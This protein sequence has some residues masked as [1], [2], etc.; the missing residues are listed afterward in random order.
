MRTR[1][2]NTYDVQLLQQ[3]ISSLP[4]FIA[5]V[6]STVIKL[7]FLECLR[8]EAVQQI[9]LIQ[10]SRPEVSAS[11]RDLL[12][13][14]SKSNFKPYSYS[15]PF[16]FRLEVSAFI[17]NVI[18]EIQ[19]LW[20]HKPYWFNILLNDNEKYFAWKTCWNWFQYPI[21]EISKLANRVRI[22]L[23]WIVII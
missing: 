16:G 7:K 19:I 20:H 1:P 14:K 22:H 12:I 13:Q 15:N 21:I 11:R 23:E 3:R 5:N 9:F 18:K 10:T 2:C 6:D 17:V 8:L 4:N